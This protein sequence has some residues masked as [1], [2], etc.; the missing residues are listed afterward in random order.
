MPWRR[1]RAGP[2]G[3]AST[4]ARSPSGTSP[5]LTSARVVG[6]RS[7]KQVGACCAR[8]E[9]IA[10]RWPEIGTW[11]L[12]EPRDY[13]ETEEETAERRWAKHALTDDPARQSG[14]SPVWR[15]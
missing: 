1:C 12:Y 2:S 4:T 5:P 6:R 15:R 3:R 8:P 13:P 14:F 10:V 9:D 7:G 11:T